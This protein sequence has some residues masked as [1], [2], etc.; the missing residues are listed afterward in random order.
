MTN[1]KVGQKVRYVRTINSEGDPYDEDDYLALIGK[2]GIII[3]IH[4]SD[5][6]VYP[7]RV[8]GLRSNDSNTD[9][10]EEEIELANQTKKELLE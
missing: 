8:L 4:E 9:V 3:K 2:T 10:R 7:I 1:Y 6:D 5:H